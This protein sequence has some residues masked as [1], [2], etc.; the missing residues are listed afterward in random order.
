MHI[1]INW[2]MIMKKLLPLIGLMLF[3]LML[4]ERVTLEA[5]LIGLG[6]SWL[7]MKLLNLKVAKDTVMPLYAPQLWLT[8]LHLISVLVKEI[9]VANFQV[10]KIVLSKTMNIE[11]KIYKFTTRLTDERL[12]VL[13]S[14]AI[15]LTPGTMT[16]ELDKSE[17]TIH[18]LNE[19]YFKALSDNPIEKILIRVE[20]RLNG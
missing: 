15:T 13:L 5:V 14:N 12:I 20:A 7:V 10:A 1:K 3:F 6:L 2:V 16:V 4:A 8:W 11:P 9:I 19:G 18:A 17:L